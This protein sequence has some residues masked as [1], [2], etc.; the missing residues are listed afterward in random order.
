MWPA[1]LILPFLCTEGRRAGSGPSRTFFRAP[2]PARADWQGERYG[3]KAEGVAHEMATGRKCRQH[4]KSLHN[5]I[6]YYGEGRKH[7]QHSRPS[8]LLPDSRIPVI[9]TT[10]QNFQGISDVL[11][12]V[13]KFQHLTKLRS[14]CSTLLVSSLNCSHVCKVTKSDC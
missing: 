11:P 13:S 1:Q 2:T 12:E 6:W 3:S 14:K 5:Y 8:G 7:T 4:D 10:I 9:C